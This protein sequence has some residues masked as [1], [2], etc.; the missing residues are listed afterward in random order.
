M[1]AIGMQI[2]KV[3]IYNREL[4]VWTELKEELV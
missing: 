2:K 3:V 4:R 1:K